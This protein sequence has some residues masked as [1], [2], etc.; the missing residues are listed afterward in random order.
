MGPSGPP[1]RAYRILYDKSGPRW[2]TMN[3]QPVNT[4]PIQG[5]TGIQKA[6]TPLGCALHRYS[7]CDTRLFY[8]R[9]D[10]VRGFTAAGRARFGEFQPEPGMGLKKRELCPAEELEVKSIRFRLSNPPSFHPM[11]FSQ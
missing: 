3:R 6:A 10:Q 1:E 9:S 5:A 2:E 4:G 11:D 7:L 8:T